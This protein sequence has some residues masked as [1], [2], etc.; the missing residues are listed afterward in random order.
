MKHLQMLAKGLTVVAISLLL[1]E[2]LLRLIDPW[3]ALRYVS[4]SRELFAHFAEDDAL[5][6]RMQPGRYTFS[7]WI[8]TVNA[9]GFRAIPDTS[10]M[11]CTIVLVGDSVTFGFGVSDTETWANLL[12]R[13]YPAVRIINTGVNGYNANNAYAIMTHVHADAYLYLL[14][15]ND[16]EAPLDW[17]RSV[18][19]MN[20][21]AMMLYWFWS[22]PQR[23]AAADGPSYLPTFWKTLDAITRLPNAQMIAFDDAPDSLGKQAAKRYPI[24]LIPNYTGHNSYADPHANAFGNQQI[25]AAISPILHSLINESCP[26]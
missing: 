17:R 2:G 18:R 24:I 21:S 12:A 4:D 26:L 5:G 8:A 20:V 1:I 9:D 25:A 23:V 16:A 7:N 14:I 15:D 13:Q 11:G 3:G 6:Y 19:D 22:N 10:P